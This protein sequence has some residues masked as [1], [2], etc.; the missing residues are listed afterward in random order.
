MPPGETGLK[1]GEY[2]GRQRIILG[3]NYGY[4]TPTPKEWK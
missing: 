4:V 2:I 3:L 1:R